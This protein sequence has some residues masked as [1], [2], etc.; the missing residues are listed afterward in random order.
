MPAIVHFL[1]PEMSLDVVTHSKDNSDILQIQKMNKII[2]S[3][4][5][6]YKN[7]QKNNGRKE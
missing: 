1:P 3:I 4:N 5:A 7:K 2:Y 6:E